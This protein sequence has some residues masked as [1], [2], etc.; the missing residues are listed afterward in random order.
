[1][2]LKSNQMKHKDDMRADIVDDP[3]FAAMQSDPVSWILV[4]KCRIIHVY[5]IKFPDF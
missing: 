1:M 4:Y 2:T 5:V 3:R